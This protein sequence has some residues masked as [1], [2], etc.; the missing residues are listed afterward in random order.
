MFLCQLPSV[1]SGCGVFSLHEKLWPKIPN[2]LE[3]LGSHIA[4]NIPLFTHFISLANSDMNRNTAGFVSGYIWTNSNVCNCI[5]RSHYDC[6]NVVLTQFRDELT[7]A[8]VLALGVCYHAC[9][10]KRREYRE[11]IARHFAPPCELRDGAE[12]ILQNISWSVINWSQLQTYVCLHHNHYTIPN[13]TYIV[14]CGM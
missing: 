12:T 2:F 1:P 7:R 5:G 4:I 8:L 9:L 10:E 13:M 3:V 6:C 14:F 11:F